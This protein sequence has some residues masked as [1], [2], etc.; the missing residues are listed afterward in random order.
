MT[1]EHGVTRL[2]A[3]STCGSAIAS[4]SS[5]CTSAAGVNMLD[6]A[7]GVRDERVD[8]QIRVAARGRML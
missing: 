6:A 7:Y 5:L 2:E 3:G 4:R 1:E 8:R